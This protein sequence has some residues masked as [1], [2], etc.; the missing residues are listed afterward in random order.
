VANEGFGIDRSILFLAMVIIGG[1]G[2]V[3]GTL[4]G[5][6]FMVMLPEAM[7]WI[8]TL[9]RAS[10]IDRALALGNSIAFLREIAIGLA[11]VFFL[12]FE[13]QGLAHRWRQIK[14]YWKLYPFSH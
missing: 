14:A 11:I 2:S 9:L 6:A 8:C 7:E 3:M 1:T 13:P 5:T 4:M 10:A 12:I